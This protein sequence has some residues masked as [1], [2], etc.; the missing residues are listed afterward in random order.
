MARNKTTGNAKAQVTRIKAADDA[1]KQPSQPAQPASSETTERPHGFFASIGDY[2]KG[3]FYEIR[4][5]RWPDRNTTWRMTGALLLFTAF[6]VIL[7]LLLDALFE[8]LF[9]LI[10]G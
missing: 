10:I 1:I 2:F 8:Y 3:A 9:K 5:V 6:F 7:I 4:Q